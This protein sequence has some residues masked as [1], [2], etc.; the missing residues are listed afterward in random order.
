[1]SCWLSLFLDSGTKG[2]GDGQD[3][4]LAYLFDLPC[5]LHV[6]CSFSSLKTTW[7]FKPSSLA[8]F[9]VWL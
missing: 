4:K 7:I 1:M 6:A 2:V 9:L 3:P 5:Y 8:P